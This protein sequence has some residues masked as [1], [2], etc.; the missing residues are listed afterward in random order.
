MF[1]I[2]FNVQD[3]HLGEMFKYFST[4]I[5]VYNLEH[6]FIPN[7]TVKD[8]KAKKVTVNYSTAK[9]LIIKHIIQNEIKYISSK[10][11]GNILTSA[12]YAYNS[13]YTTAY[14]LVE[15]GILTRV[16]KGRYKVKSKSV[17]PLSDGPLFDKAIA[18]SRENEKVNEKVNEKD[19]ENETIQKLQL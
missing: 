7:V 4:K 19:K 1:H 12:N 3:K 15:A 13:A 10:E 6:S 2:E 14:N 16:E 11:I 8:K 9:E 17:F 18:P 5:K